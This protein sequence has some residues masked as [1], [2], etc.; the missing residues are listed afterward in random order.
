VS[1]PREKTTVKDIKW[2]IIQMEK[3]AIKDEAKKDFLHSLQLAKASPLWSD[4]VDFL[5]EMLEEKVRR[6]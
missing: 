6:F 3:W 5:A 4:V 1:A 2:V